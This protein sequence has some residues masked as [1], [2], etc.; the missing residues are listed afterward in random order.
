MK[1]KLEWT[2]ILPEGY[3]P[4]EPNN[5]ISDITGKFPGIAPDNE[6][7]MVHTFEADTIDEAKDYAKMFT[8]EWGINIFSVFGK[9]DIYFTEE[10]L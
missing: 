5:T 4:Q 10:D 6:W 1:L 2:E 7:E 3:L 9:D 8:D